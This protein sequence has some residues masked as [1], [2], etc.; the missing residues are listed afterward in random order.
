MSGTYE[1]LQAWRL[2]MDL[3]TEVYRCTGLF[4]KAELY[5]LTDQMRRSAVSIPSNIAEGKGRS[6]DREL[7]QFL[8]HARGSLYELQTQIKL[9]TRLSYLESEPANKIG[10]QAAEVGKVLNGLIRSFRRTSSVE[11]DTTA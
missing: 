11:S 6:S 7:L 3:A 5:G 10:L 9:A 2:A 8:N 4:P 1:D